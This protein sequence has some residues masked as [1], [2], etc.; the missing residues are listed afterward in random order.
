MSI[1]IT[2]PTPLAAARA[3]WR[4]YAAH[5]ERCAECTRSGDG[6]VWPGGI[7]RCETGAYLNKRALDYDDETW[8]ALS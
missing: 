6:G 1:E 7:G 8:K 2:R 3:A 4:C 5:L